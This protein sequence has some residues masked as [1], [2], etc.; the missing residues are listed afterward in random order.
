MLS[1][2]LDPSN[3]QHRGICP[4]LVENSKEAEF[5]DLGNLGGGLRG[6][7]GCETQ[8][9]SLKGQ[10]NAEAQCYQERHSGPSLERCVN[11]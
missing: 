5:C 6:A 11:L 10:L 4:S 7:E 1:P 8:T 9:Q 2:S 3:L